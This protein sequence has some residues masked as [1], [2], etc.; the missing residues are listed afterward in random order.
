MACAVRAGTTWSTASRNLLYRLLYLAERKAVSSCRPLLRL[1]NAQDLALLL[2]AL[3]RLDV[4]KAP[5]GADVNL[6]RPVKVHIPREFSAGS[7]ASHPHTR[8]VGPGGRGPLRNPMK[9]R[10]TA[11]TVRRRNMCIAAPRG[12][13]GCVHIADTKDE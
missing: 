2:P 4:A 8:Q 7:R 6:R 9:A 5:G 13:P 3:N 12:K 1:D 11:G 10:Q